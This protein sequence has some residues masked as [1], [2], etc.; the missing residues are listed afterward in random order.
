MVVRSNCGTLLPFEIEGGTAIIGS[1]VSKQQRALGDLTPPP[2]L[3]L[4]FQ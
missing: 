4:A 1:D 2:T 3:W